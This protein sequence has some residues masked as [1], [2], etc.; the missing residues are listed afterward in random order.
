MKKFFMI[1]C[2]MVMSLAFVSL[3]GCGGSDSDD[4]GEAPAADSQYIGSWTATGAE[5]K[6][7]AVDLAEVLEDGD[8][9]VTLN[10]DGTA[11]S[12]YVE[13]ATGTW[14]ESDDGFKIRGDDLK[15]D[16]VDEGDGTVSTEIFGFK[17]YFEKTAAEE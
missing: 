4:S 1:L 8:Y 15:M 9:I 13:E 3:T 11:T 14:T 16:F 17:M 6:D 2:V 12:L 5:F 10:E 7:E